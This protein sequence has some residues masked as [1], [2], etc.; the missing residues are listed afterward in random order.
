MD[1]EGAHTGPADAAALLGGPPYAGTVCVSAK[2][3][4]EM[5]PNS[6]AASLEKMVS[7][8]GAVK[9]GTRPCA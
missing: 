9:D 7:K 1:R 8:S 3:F 2:V 5:E 6:A 4:A